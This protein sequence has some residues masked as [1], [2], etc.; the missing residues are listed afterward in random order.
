MLLNIDTFSYDMKELIGIDLQNKH[1]VVDNSPLPSGGANS[2]VDLST[3]LSVRTDFM[4][5]YNIKTLVMFSGLI[6]LVIAF[7]LLSVVYIYCKTRN[8]FGQKQ[9]K[10]AQE[11]DGQFGV[12]WL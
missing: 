12:A 4:M 5:S 10:L 9:R 6:I 11:S 2:Q 3:M 7:A 1:L 8:D